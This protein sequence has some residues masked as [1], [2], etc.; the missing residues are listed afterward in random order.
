MLELVDTHRHP[1]PDADEPS[2]AIPADVRLADAVVC[3]G[4]AGDF[5][6]VRQCARREGLHYALGVHPMQLRSP[7]DMAREIDA[8]RS[9]LADNLND[10]LLAAVG[11][12][13]LDAYPGAAPLELDDQIVLFAAMLEAA[14]ENELP[15]SVHSRRALHR[16]MPLLKKY[17]VTGVLHAFAGSYE[18]ACQCLTLGLKLGFGPALTYEGSRRIRD[19]FA[20]LPEDAFV[21]ETDAPFMLT[22]TRRAAGACR[23]APGDLAEVLEAAAEVRGLSRERAAQLSTQNA[24]AVFARLRH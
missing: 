19:V 2:C 12:I 20:R 5:D 16:V 11:E 13:G 9:A 22:Q 15:V 4:G 10:P 18:Q 1:C 23:C 21:L 17:R 3:A 8:L 24:L 14:S 6:L 7:C